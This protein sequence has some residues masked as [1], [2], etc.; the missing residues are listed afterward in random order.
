[1]G[2]RLC[3]ISFTGSVVTSEVVPLILEFVGFPLMRVSSH[4]SGFIIGDKVLIHYPI[5]DEDVR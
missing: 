1:M 3:R 2:N 5:N 4:F